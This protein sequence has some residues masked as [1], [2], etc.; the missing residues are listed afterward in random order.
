[1]RFKTLIFI[2]LSFSLLFA[3]S[4]YN[5]GYRQYIRYVKHIPHYG[6][7]APMLLKKLNVKNE[8]DLKALFQ[9]NAELL[10]K[11][12]AKFNPEASKGLEKIIKKGKITSLEAFLTGIVNGKIPP[13]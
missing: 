1:M 9:N 3:L 10:I 7:K 13:G 5:E 12:T 11:N 8:D 6:I 4:P 2:C